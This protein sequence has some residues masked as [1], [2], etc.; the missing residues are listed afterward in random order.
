MIKKVGPE[1]PK[2]QSVVV[3]TEP[4]K[5]VYQNLPAKIGCPRESKNFKESVPEG[6]D[7]NIPVESVMAGTVG[8]EEHEVIYHQGGSIPLSKLFPQIK[9][10]WRIKIRVTKKS[11]IRAWNN[12]KG[13]GKLQNLEFIDRE[14]SHMQGT[15]FREMVDMFSETFMVGNCYEISQGVIKVY[16]TKFTQSTNSHCFVFDKFTKVSAC[17]DDPEIPGS[18]NLDAEVLDSVPFV[19]LDGV[20]SR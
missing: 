13:V 14:G 18:E 4:I 8:V 12:A 2:Q 7:L 17:D 3:F 20:A 11:E 15:L 10:C 19:N 9:G 1:G 5:I 16:N 6:I